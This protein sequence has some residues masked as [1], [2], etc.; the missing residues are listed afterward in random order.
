MVAFEGHVGP[1]SAVAF[2]PTGSL[3]ATGDNDGKIIL[4]ERSTRKQLRHISEQGDSV[5]GLIFARDSRSLYVLSESSFFQGPPGAPIRSFTVADGKQVWQYDI[6]NARGGRGRGSFDP[7][8]GISDIALN[9][10]QL[11]ALNA[12][13]ITLLNANTG[14]LIRGQ[15][16]ASKEQ[17]IGGF[18]SALAYSKEN[19]ELTAWTRRQT[20]WRG[21]WAMNQIINQP[22]PE[23]MRVT[24]TENGMGSESENA[25]YAAAFSPDGKFLVLGGINPYLQLLSVDTGKEVRRISRSKHKKDDPVHQIAFAPDGRTIVWCSVNDAFVRIADFA[26]GR[27]VRKLPAL[28]GGASALAFSSDGNTLLMGCADSTAIVWDLAK[29]PPH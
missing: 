15:V 22:S 9:G 19:N 28:G 11:A 16:L 18:A 26:S 8:S 4:W 21:D 7:M 1:I 13:S 23:A 27:E 17:H 20:L 29:L 25:P 12:D 10:D 24:K 3:I 5:Q 2:S 6:L 14:K